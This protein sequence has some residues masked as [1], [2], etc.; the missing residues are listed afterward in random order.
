MEI[1]NIEIGHYQHEDR[2]INKGEPPS[3]EEEMAQD[4]SSPYSALASRQ[5]R[6]HDQATH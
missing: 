6:P 3:V 1:Q 5:S 4:V 2:I